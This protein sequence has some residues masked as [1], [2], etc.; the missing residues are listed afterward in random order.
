M[1][2]EDKD[3]SL[4]ESETTETEGGDTGKEV[5]AS[6]EG[7][8]PSTGGEE[9]DLASYSEGV[10]KRI[11]KLTYKTREAERREQEA[12]EYAR[13]VKLE[14]D[15]LKKRETTLSKS[16]ET[17]AETRLQTQERLYKDQY[18]FAVDS[19][20][21]DKQVE[22][23]T[24]LAQLAVERERLRNYR[25]YRREAEEVPE[26]P[27]PQPVQ[28][29]Q[30]D[31]KAQEW[32][33]RN[34][35]FGAE[36]GMTAV[37]YEIHEDLI[38]EGFN[39]SG[40]DYYKELDSRM[41]KEFPNKFAAPAAKKPASSVA[42]GRPTQVKKSS[43]NIELTETQKTIAKRLGVSYDDYKRQLKLVQDRID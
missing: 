16:L 38:S 40:D 14:L 26:R 35:W 2:E 18:K 22:V 25:Q 19:G 11:N 12:L 5:D 29:Q 8:K 20:D 10:K 34:T 7:E 28:R 41:R 30:P 37:A 43:G 42:S 31:R 13:A 17:E 1:L 36:R 27:M 33:E 21:T 24:H 39:A 4:S 9:D 15:S 23:Q 32:A 6:S 3:E